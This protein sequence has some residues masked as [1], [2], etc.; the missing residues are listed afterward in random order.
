MVYD[1]VN[2]S[3]EGAR[4]RCEGRWAEVSQ[5]FARDDNYIIRLN[6]KK[7]GETQWMNRERAS[8]R[9]SRYE[10]GCWMK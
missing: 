8:N 3:S 2:E 5:V 10:D 7:W 9:E 6:A 1:E 4:D